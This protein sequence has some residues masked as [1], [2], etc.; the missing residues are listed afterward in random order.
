VKI[1]NGY[2]KACCLN[3]ITSAFRRPGILTQCNGFG[4]IVACVDRTYAANI[5]HWKNTTFEKR[6][7]HL[8]RAQTI[9]LAVAD[10]GLEA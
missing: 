4:E 2:Q 1:I 6:Q 3:N 9:E 10:E 7:F 8:L 5:R